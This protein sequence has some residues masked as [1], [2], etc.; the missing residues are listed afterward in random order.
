MANRAL[1]GAAMAVGVSVS[2][3][4]LLQGKLTAGLVGFV[5]GAGIFGGLLYGWEQIRRR[6]L[7]KLGNLPDHLPVRPSLSLE[8][9]GR[10]EMV[11]DTITKWLNERYGNVEH[12]AVNAE[13]WRL[14][15]LTS[16]SWW[17]AIGERIDVMINVE[18]ENLTLMKVTSQPRLSTIALDGGR[19]YENV[20][21]IQ[22]VVS[23]AVGES[24]IRVL[25][26]GEQAPS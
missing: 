4:A 12:S 26:L 15:T 21:R 6:R 24:R 17:S 25:G 23:E 7:M 19:N 1:L 2:L 8:I 10:A 20:R 22:N 18:Q 5:V 16:R 14:T 13:T 11:T 3:P 9:D